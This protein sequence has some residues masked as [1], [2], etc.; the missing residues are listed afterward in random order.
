MTIIP[1]NYRL[2]NKASKLYALRIAVSEYSRHIHQGS[3]MGV[4]DSDTLVP[5]SRRHSAKMLDLALD[6]LQLE[7]GD[8]EMGVI[9]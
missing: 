7:T 1:R 9:I 8:G 6:E 3:D 2:K 5:G 4:G